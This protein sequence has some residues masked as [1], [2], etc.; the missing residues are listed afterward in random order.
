M[1]NNK[2]LFLFT[3]GPVQSFIAQ[4]RKTQDLYAGSLLLSNL[5]RTAINQLDDRANVIFPFTYPDEE[6]KWKNKIESL[7][8]RFVAIINKD[9]SELQ[10]LGEQIENAVR[11]KWKSLSFSAILDRQKDYNKLSI[12]QG[13][14]QQIEQH[15]DIFWLFEPLIDYEESFK[16][17][18]RKMGAIKNVRDFEQYNYNGVG[19]AGRK[20]SLDGIRNVKFYRM[21]EK[22]QKKGKQYI[23]DKLLFATDNCVFDYDEKLDDSILQPGE[24]LSAVS[25]VKR[26]YLYNNKEKREFKSTSEIA[27]MDWVQ[28]FS[29]KEKKHLLDNYK[30]LYVGG[31]SKTFNTQLYF[32]DNLNID[33]F[34]NQGIALKD[35]SKEALGNGIKAL[36]EL[37]KIAKY[38]DSEGNDKKVKQSKYY[39]IVAFDG[40]SMG[41]WLSEAKSEEE[42]RAFSRLL[43]E[44]AQKAKDYI[45]NGKG[46]VVYTG[47][48]DFLGFVNLSYLFDVL[49]WL[50]DEFKENVGIPAKVLLGRGSNFTFSAGIAV[51]H[52]KE[53]LGIVLSR[54]KAMEEKAKDW[55]IDKN[56]FGLAVLKGSGEQHETIWS[57]DNDSLEHIQ[58]LVQKLQDGTFSNTFITSIQR[59]FGRL[60]D[61]DGK[62]GEDEKFKAFSDLL[63]TEFK[64]LAKRSLI[65]KKDSIAVTDL[66]NHI[67]NGIFIEQFHQNEK[68]T[69]RN[70]FELLNM[71]NF[72]QRSTNPSKIKE[73]SL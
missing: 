64:R 35:K 1:S 2:Y 63:E 59:E 4:A 7:P 40:D 73:L 37:T 46:Q 60:L 25:F 67:W 38:K 45:N 5:V 19:E 65:Q 28:W 72:I 31:S 12:D 54:A 57:F 11:A 52:Y 66:V 36:K 9:V 27:L 13:F 58:Y 6:Y 44:F 24:G 34:N 49:I 15:L 48:D 47:G 42:H 68:A 23:Q 20:C 71:A 39:A 53:P 33:Y 50:R 26:C 32:E 30:N 70:F 43:I 69:I 51:A 14:T 8:N 16:L 61:L 17:L 18:E 29:K 21:T 41:E 22:Q 3:I 55:S 10:K 56:A 62:M